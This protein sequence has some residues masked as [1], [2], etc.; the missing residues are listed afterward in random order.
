MAAL[1]LIVVGLLVVL[2][3]IGLA[4]PAVA[5]RFGRL[6]RNEQQRTRLAQFEESLDAMNPDSAREESRLAWVRHRLARGR[7]DVE[8]EER[9]PLTSRGMLVLA[10]AGMRGVVTVAAVQ[11]IPADTKQVATVVLAA[12]LVALFTLVVFG[13]TLPWVIARLKFESESP[14]DKR[15]A[16]QALLRRIGESAIDA[17]GP[18]EEQTIGGEPLDPELVA[19]MT[20]P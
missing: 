2:R 14:E 9:E 13:L 15:D 12:F 3:F 11:T 18:L 10:W 6:Q 7:A 8:F 1:V 19:T 20:L 4:W 5:G 17:M 16:T